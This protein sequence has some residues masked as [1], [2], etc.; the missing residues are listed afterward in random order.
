MKYPKLLEKGSTIGIKA[1]A[2]LKKHIMAAIKAERM[3]QGNLN[4]SL[5]RFI[6]V[7]E[8]RGNGSLYVP[9]PFDI[10]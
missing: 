4:T 2:E 7:L 6:S 3:R 5:N 9:F 8:Y 1:S 10:L